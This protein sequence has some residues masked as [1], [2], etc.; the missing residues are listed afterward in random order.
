MPGQYYLFWRKCFMVDRTKQSKGYIGISDKCVWK[1]LLS[2]VYTGN[3]L[4]G[5]IRAIVV[6]QVILL[7]LKSFQKMLQVE[8]LV[9]VMLK[10]SL[11]RKSKSSH[12][13]LSGPHVL[14]WCFSPFRR[15]TAQLKRN[16]FYGPI[17]MKERFLILSLQSTNAFHYLHIFKTAL[18][19]PG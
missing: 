11:W 6:L 1:S 13:F 19:G 2:R 12:Y 18:G 7:N 10:S 9:K 16:V 4:S 8:L 3:N 14:P 15:K 17:S 5:F